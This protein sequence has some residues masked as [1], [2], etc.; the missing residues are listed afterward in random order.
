MLGKTGWS[1]TRMIFGD[2]MNHARGR[3]VSVY[4]SPLAWIAQGSTTGYY[5]GM[6]LPG[7]RMA[8]Q[9]LGGVPPFFGVYRITDFLPASG[10]R[11]S[12]PVLRYSGTSGCIFHR[13]ELVEEGP[14]KT[15][16]Q[17]SGSA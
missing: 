11:H 1:S 5:K 2:A 3:T 4:C 14:G 9:Q 12:R 8:G 16:S 6:P 13:E 10:D 15:I 17:T 7:Y